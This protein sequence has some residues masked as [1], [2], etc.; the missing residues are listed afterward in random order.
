[1]NSNA[2]AGSRAGTTKADNGYRQVYVHGTHYYEHRLAVFYMTGKWP[3]QEVDHQFG[4]HDD[5]RWE[6]IR[7]AS[8]SENGQN[9]RVAKRGTTSGLL[10]VYWDKKRKRWV[11]QLVLH[12]KKLFVKFFKDKYE[13]H[14]AYLDAKV[15]FH[16]RQTLV[17][18]ANGNQ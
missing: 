2:M 4:I 15:R 9:R 7:K 17:S 16:P 1:M 11:A 8:P 18:T 5:N 3:D 10:G 12:R 6:E 13:A 14:Q